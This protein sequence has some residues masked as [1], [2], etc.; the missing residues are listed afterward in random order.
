MAL[1][2]C[3][4]GPSNATYYIPWSSFA[5]WN[6]GPLALACVPFGLFPTLI[7][8]RD[9]E[10]EANEEVLLGLPSLRDFQIGKRDTAS[11][12]PN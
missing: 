3:T 10:P 5:P 9:V 6:F 7:Y 1:H 4:E 11:E 8:F 2:F 12:F